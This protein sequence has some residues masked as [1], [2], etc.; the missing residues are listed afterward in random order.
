MTDDA[1]EEYA[2]PRY[3]DPE[4]AARIVEARRRGERYTDIAAREGVSWQRIQRICEDAGLTARSP[5]AAPPKRCAWAGCGKL[6]RRREA[7]YCSRGCAAAADPFGKRAYERRRDSG[8][9]WQEIA[10]DAAHGRRPDLPPAQRGREARRVAWRYAEAHGLPWPLPDRA[11][12]ERIARR[13]EEGMAEVRE[14]VERERRVLA[15]RDALPND[16]TISRDEAERFLVELYRIG[17][18]FGHIAERTNCSW[19]YVESV[20]RRRAPMLIR[21]RAG[22]GKKAPRR[23]PLLDLRELRKAWRAEE[24]RRQRDRQD[25]R[26][27]AAYLAGEPLPEISRRESISRIRAWERISAASPAPLPRPGT[28]ARR[29]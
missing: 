16:R 6:M 2:V 14:M 21:P 26:M 17:M 4:R 25:A 27:L 5:A 8:A 28:V 29:T 9:T 18:R 12:A 3:R 22:R 19:D 13:D 11:A 20:V 7:V 15:L 10:E 23:S 1:G 24:L